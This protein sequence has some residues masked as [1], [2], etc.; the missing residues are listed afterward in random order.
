MIAIQTIERIEYIH[1]KF[2]LH[3]DIKPANFLVG[4]PDDFQI[5]L[6]D[7]GIAKKYRSSR[8][9][10]HIKNVKI[11]KLFGTSLFINTHLYYL[12]LTYFNKKKKKLI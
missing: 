10:K 3:R 7:F 4:N 1:S 11:N 2:Y 5:Y 9:G 12:I 6:I 8:T